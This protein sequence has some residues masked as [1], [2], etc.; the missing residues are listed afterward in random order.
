M[1]QKG[2]LFCLFSFPVEKPRGLFGVF[3]SRSRQKMREKNETPS[4]APPSR[5]E[6]KKTKRRKG[7][8][9]KR[10]MLDGKDYLRLNKK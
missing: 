1:F 4:P 10:L 5:G 3:R 7:K 2:R 6:K 8:S 9:K